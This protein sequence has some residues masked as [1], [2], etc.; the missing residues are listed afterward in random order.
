MKPSCSAANYS[1]LWKHLL[2]VLVIGAQMLSLPASAAPPSAIEIQ[3][4]VVRVVDGDTVVFLS[5]T[6]QRMKLRLAGI[7]APEMAMPYGIMAKNMLIQLVG[8]GDVT[9]H[10]TKLDRFGRAI[11][12]VIA[13][14]GDVNLALINQGLAWHYKRYAHEQT[15]SD[16]DA[17]AQSE[18]KAKAR[19]AGLWKETMPVPPWAYRACRK[20]S[21]S[22]RHTGT[23]SDI[24][25]EMGIFR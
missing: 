11:A 5:T 9:V 23:G 19:K 25:Q 20:K 10:A 7:D 13:K 15:S 18:N 21:L 24:Q 16:A 2:S 4:K 6:G 3:G 12:K 17:Y 22:C 14:D 1:A 8:A